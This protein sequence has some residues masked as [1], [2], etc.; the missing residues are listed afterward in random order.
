MDYL[1]MQWEA[2]ADVTFYMASACK[3]GQ[4]F[5][6]FMLGTVSRDWIIVT[7]HDLS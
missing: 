1:H 3:N 5:P 7:N 4:T 2:D 6:I